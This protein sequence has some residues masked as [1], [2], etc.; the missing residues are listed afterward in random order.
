MLW[1]LRGRKREREGRGTKEVVMEDE[2]RNGWVRV[3]G[4]SGGGFEF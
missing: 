3:F 1:Q 4:F 2:E